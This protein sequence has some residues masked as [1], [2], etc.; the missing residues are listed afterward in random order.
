MPLTE[1]RRIARTAGSRLD[2]DFA[3]ALSL[4]HSTSVVVAT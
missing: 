4:T 2:H 3:R 1:I